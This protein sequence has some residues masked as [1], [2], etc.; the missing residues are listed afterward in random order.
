MMRPS[1]RRLLLAIVLLAVLGK[2]TDALLGV[3][4][5]WAA[6]KWA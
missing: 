4:E 3:F 2:A 5:K 6:K 1:L